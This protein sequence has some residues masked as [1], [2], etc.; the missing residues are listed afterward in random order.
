MNATS[1]LQIDIP[2][3]QR[4]TIILIRSLF[5]VNS[6]VSNP[7]ALSIGRGCGNCA[8]LAVGG[9]N[10]SPADSHLAVFLAG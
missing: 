3:L 9:D 6:D 1:S 7:L 8:A 5:V 10:Y 2:R 4:L